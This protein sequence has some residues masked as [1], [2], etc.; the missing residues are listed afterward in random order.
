[1]VVVDNLDQTIAGKTRGYY[2]DTKVR[3]FSIMHIAY[4]ISNMAE[5]FGGQVCTVKNIGRA[6]VASGHIISYWATA[7]PKD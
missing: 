5:R 1:V 2:A 4:I 6:L 7:N 3:R